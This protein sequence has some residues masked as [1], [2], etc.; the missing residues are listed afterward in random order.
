MLKELHEELVRLYAKWQIWETLFG[1]SQHRMDLLNRSAVTFFGT[2]W[3]TL[4]Y[5]VVL[6]ICRMTDPA[7]GDRRNLV[8]EQL[9]L[10]A[11]DKRHADLMDSLPPLMAEVKEKCA[12]FRKIRNKKLAHRDLKAALN[13][14]EY[15]VPGV[16]RHMFDEALGAIANVVD[17]FSSHWTGAQLGFS[18]SMIIPGG[19]DELVEMLKRSLEYDLLLGECSALAEREYKGEFRDV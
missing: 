17:E 5:D 1:V 18:K 3:E 2:V 8:L 6:G 13:A 10:A 15:P 12:F 9:V 11:E 7:G 4:M 19:A 14:E 16:S